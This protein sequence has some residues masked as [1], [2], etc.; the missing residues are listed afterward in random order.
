M[1]TAL[2]PDAREQAAA[3]LLTV[4]AYRPRPVLVTVGWFGIHRMLA[5]LAEHEPDHAVEAEALVSTLE[6]D[7]ALTARRTAG[8]DQVL[9][10]CAATNREVAVIS[11]LS[12]HAVLA[13]LRAHVIASHVAAVAARQ[14]L[15]LS[16]FDAGHTAQWTADLLRVPLDSCLFVSGCSTRLHA[17]RQAGA[18]GLGC[19]C[20]QDRRKHLANADTPVVSD[21]ATLAHALLTS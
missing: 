6:L 21:L 18:A 17:V 7:A 8:L 16:A 12:E 14:G 1:R 5:F 13:A 11:D 9:A 3:G 20:G 19:E 4:R 10:A 2:G 15:D